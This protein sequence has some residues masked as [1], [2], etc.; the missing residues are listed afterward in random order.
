MTLLLALG[1]AASTAETAPTSYPATEMLGAFKE[2]CADSS[3]TDAVRA[4][5]RATG[6][7]EFTP[8]AAS[9]LG[10]LFITGK[11]MV[12]DMAAKGAKV[13]LTPFFAFH[14]VVAGR[15]IEA[16][17]D[18][19]TTAAAGKTITVT[20]CQVYDFSAP[21]MLD[22]ATLTTWVG[23]APDKKVEYPGQLTAISWDN[24]LAGPGSQL[25]LAFAP[26]TSTFADPNRLMVLGLVIKSQH[27]TITP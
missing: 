23:H 5:A 11:S 19:A 9:N 16:S 13:E 21:G 14:K 17:A 15:N 3:S 4:S 22:D 27:Y 20:G 8:P 7:V 1:L 10:K 26:S 18:A 2:L 25:K 12:A 24:G 6:W